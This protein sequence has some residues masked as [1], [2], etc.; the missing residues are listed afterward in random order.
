MATEVVAAR[1][2][3]IR[4][5]RLTTMLDDSSAHIRLLIAPAGYG[6]TTLAREW[7]GEPERDDVWYRGGPASADVAALAAGISEAVGSIVPDAGKRMRERVRATGHPEEDVEILA[8]LFAEDVQAWSANAWLAIDDY[9]FAMESV[10][11]ERF[12][13]L[14]TQTTPIQMLIT[15]RRRP[16]WATARRI[17]YGELQEIDRRTLAMEEVEAKAVLRRDSQEVRELTSH[18]KGWPAVIGLAAYATALRV[19]ASDLPATLH[20]YFAEEILQSA[21][22]GTQEKLCF[23]AMAP[24]V[25]PDLIGSMWG[26]RAA[27][28]LVEAGLRLGVLT[29]QEGGT[30]VIHPLLREFLQ[31][32]AKGHREEAE[33][34]TRL[35]KYFLAEGLWDFAFDVAR[36]ASIPELT[37]EAIEGGLDSMLSQGRLA[38]IQLWVD[39]AL[40][41]H[42]DLPIVDLAEAELA[43]RHGEHERAYVLAAQAASQAEDKPQ[44]RARSHI[45]AGHSALLASRERDGLEHFRHAAELAE[46]WEQQR[47]ALV[48][49]YFAASELDEPDAIDALRKLEAADDRS[50]DGILRLEVLRLTRASR[51]GG[52]TAALESSLLKRHLVDRANDPLGLTA[53]LHMLATCL[54]LSARYAEALEFTA[55]QLAIADRYRLALPVVHVFLNRAIGELGLRRFQRCAKALDEVQRHVP[56]TGDLYLDS[57]IRAI[58]A[59]LLLASDRIQEAVELTQDRGEQISSPPLLAEYLSCR[60][61]ALACIGDSTGAQELINQAAKAYPESVEYRVLGHCANAVIHLQSGDADNASRAVTEAWSSA[62]TTGNFDSFVCAYRAESTLIDIFPSDQ[63]SR[64]ELGR[65]LARASDMTLGRHYAIPVEARTARQ[66]DS[67]TPREAEVLH[68]LQQGASNRTIAKRLFISEATVKVHLRHIYEKLGVRNRSELLARRSTRL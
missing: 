20:T 45:R 32:Q 1:Q 62:H 30:F 5:P 22:P 31:A 4:R 16:S 65:L 36:Q 39:F 68:E 41:E 13:D 10:A 42:L 12:V 46:A 18:A 11:S 48:G 61:L 6:K 34:A 43:F 23:L 9:Q 40:S 58:R 35:V 44:L 54:N 60:A 55:Q 21:D 24:L 37:E 59:R 64:S 49:L 56:A 67:L 19:P 8:E 66:S 63:V 29:E 27:G 53:F 51:T 57:T 47:E 38:T 3:I 50:P 2:R 17:L 33:Y 52:I 14:L 28:R 15:S 7:L 26:E 25:S